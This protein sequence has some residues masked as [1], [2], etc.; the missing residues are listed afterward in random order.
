[1]ANHPTKKI[2]LTR[3]EKQQLKT[4]MARNQQKGKKGPRTAQDTIP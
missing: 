4:L 3:A 1:M 2:K